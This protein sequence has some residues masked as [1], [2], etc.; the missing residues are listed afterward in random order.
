MDARQRLAQA[1]QEYDDYVFRRSG[2][3]I[4]PVDRDR[5]EALWR[6]VV[7]ARQEAEDDSESSE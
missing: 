2:V 5:V 7:I 6:A 4:E 1:K 3:C